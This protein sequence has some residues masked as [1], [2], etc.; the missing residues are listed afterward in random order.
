VLLFDID[1]TLLWSGY[2]GTRALNRTFAD[3]YGI[4]DA[5]RD[6]RPDGKTDPLIFREIFGRRLPAVSPEREMGRLA[7]RYLVYL[8][9]E[10]QKT[11]A[12]RLMP[13]VE[14]L[15]GALSASPGLTLGLATGNLE[16]AAW[17]KLQRGGIAPRFRF[18]GFGSDSPNRTELIRAAVR[19][20][21]EHLGEE[22]P[23]GQVWV[24]GDTPLDIRHAR[25]AG[26]KVV[27]VATGRSSVEDL[28]RCEPDRV[29]PDLSQTEEVLSFFLGEPEPPAANP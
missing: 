25:Q 11:T 6:V 15:L 24:I 1:M 21:E 23:N 26:V 9:E 5:F 12:F 22:L 18:G 20:A 14:A 28:A 2:A 3:L 16:R 8:E 4:E 13:G 7:E 29:F 17:L 27:A 10:L 19:R